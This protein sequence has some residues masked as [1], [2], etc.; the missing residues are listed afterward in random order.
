VLEYNRA[1][2]LMCNAGLFQTIIT[3]PL[4]TV[5][6]RLSVGPEQG[7]QY[8][9]IVDCVRQMVRTEGVGGL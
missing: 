6:T 4:E 2:V 9:G 8:K 3:Y 7:V 5:R 1:L